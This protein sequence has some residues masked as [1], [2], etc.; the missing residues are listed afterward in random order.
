LSSSLKE[1]LITETKPSKEYQDLKNH[2]EILIKGQNYIEA[3]AITRTINYLE[4]SD[5]FKSQKERNQ[6]IK[7]KLE[8]LHC[9]HVLEKQAL[10]K[11]N[12][13]IDDSLLKEKKD[14]LD[15]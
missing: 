13:E 4:K 1:N 8:R 10:I 11:K 7:N 2:Y 12:K 5:N 14:T 3:N 15:Q 6:I 9:K